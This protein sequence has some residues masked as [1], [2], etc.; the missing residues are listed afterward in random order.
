MKKIITLF[1]ATLCFAG[2]GLSQA[3]AMNFSG[4]D[5]NGNQ[6]DLFSDLDAGK[7]VVL[8]FYMPNCGSCPP[9]AAQIQ[10]MAANVNA[11]YPGL[12]KGYAFPYQNSSTCAS[13]VSWVTNNSLDWYS[14]LDSGA[15][16]VA[17]YGGFG[18][19]TVVLLGGDNREVLFVTQDFNTSDTTTMRDLILGMLEADVQELNAA[20]SLD[21][22]PNP[23]T[24]LI[25][26]RFEATAPTATIELIDL[27][28]KQVLV[29]EK[30]QLQHGMIIEE[31]NVSKIPAGSYL[32]RVH[33]DGKIVTDKINVL[34]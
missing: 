6:V 10:T 13:V 29:I 15:A 1:T 2:F 11:S 25:T 33:L 31:L 27:E 17:Y 7:A 4:A 34:H 3:T 18:M 12:V 20:P 5:C 26:V 24:E 21:V 14:P 9:P 32:V 23:S 16:Q 19:P 30:Q 8:F 22:F 28:G